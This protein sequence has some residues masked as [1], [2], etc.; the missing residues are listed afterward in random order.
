MSKRDYYRELGQ[1]H[2]ELVKLQE[3]VKYK[4]LKV[5]A[6]F[7][8]RDAAGKGGAIKSFM[9]PLNP[10]YARVVALGV[11]TEREKTQWYFQ[12]YV[13]HLP[14][15]GEMVFFDRS[16][17]NRA[18]VERV[19]GFCTEEEYREFL[20]SCPE[21]ERMLV[22]SGIILVKYWF[23]VSDE[24]QERRFQARLDDPTRR[25]KLSPMDLES[26]TRWVEY[27]KAKD[28]MFKYTDIKQAPWYVVNADNKR[29]A[30]LNCISHFLSLIPYEDLTP[31]PIE[32]PPRQPDTGYVRPPITD[33][34]FVPEKY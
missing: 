9:E 20:R 30:R 8:G 24:E 34:T 33:Q 16:W 23:S 28:E 1:L 15:A 29:R 7:E 6:V 19:M 21:F 5:V 11:P 22:R 17:Y 25:W 10:R 14:A 2:I 12:R 27:S 4:G 18:G 32:L 13:A 26:R 3:W 31:E